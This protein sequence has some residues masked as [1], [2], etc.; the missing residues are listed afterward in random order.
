MKADPEAPLQECDVTPCCGADPCAYEAATIETV[1]DLAVKAER[2]RIVAWLR[3]GVETWRDL[4]PLERIALET[5]AG[6]IER[7]EHHAK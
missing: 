7:G 6:E 4:A 1:A 3:E 5:V 2:A